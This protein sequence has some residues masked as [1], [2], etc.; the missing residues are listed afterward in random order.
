MQF[1]FNKAV[2]KNNLNMEFSLKQMILYYEF[3]VLR[4]LVDVLCHAF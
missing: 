2:A 1:D 4:R 3:H